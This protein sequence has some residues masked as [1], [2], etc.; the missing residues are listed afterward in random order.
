MIFIGRPETNSALAAWS[1]RLGLD[2]DAALFKT[3]GKTYASERNAL[4]FTAT[5]PLDAAHMVLVYAGNSPLE[6]ARALEATGQNAAIVLE[7]GKTET[8]AKGRE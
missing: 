4:V 8:A 7:D 3:Q 5:N 2:Y 1:E 6:T